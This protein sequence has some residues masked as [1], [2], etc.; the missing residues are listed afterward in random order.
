MQK[1]ETSKIV[2]WSAIVTISVFL[3]TFVVNGDPECEQL[4]QVSGSF[5]TLE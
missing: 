5:S 4:L 2:R 1:M 3:T